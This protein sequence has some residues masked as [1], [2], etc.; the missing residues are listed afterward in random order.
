M[1]WTRNDAWQ[2][3]FLALLCAFACQ[4]ARAQT[5]IPHAQSC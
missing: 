4:N 3:L 1:R 5:R 2:A